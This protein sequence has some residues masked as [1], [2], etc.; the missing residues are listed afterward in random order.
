MGT[1]IGYARLN[2]KDQSLR[3]QTDAL[4]ASGC[5]EIIFQEHKNGTKQDRPELEHALN[6]LGS[7]DTLVIYKLDRLSSSLKNLLEIARRIQ[8]RGAALKCINP[9]IDG[10]TGKCFFDV[11]SAI[12]EFEQ[13]LIKERTRAGLRA[14]KQLGK[15]G[16][17]PKSI[18]QETITRARALLVQGNSKTDIAKSLNLSRASLYRLLGSSE[19]SAT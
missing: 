1:L 10:S 6:A 11:L 14:A 8:H 17:R 19:V 4:K 12:A 7:G 3:P 5:N 2:A 13:D 15:L 9:P 18:S 16:G